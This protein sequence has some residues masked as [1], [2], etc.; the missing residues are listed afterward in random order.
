MRQPS[1]DS[2]SATSRR[3]CR[4]A[5]S[6]AARC[7]R[8]PAQLASVGSR[9]REGDHRVEAHESAAV[10]V[11]CA[12]GNGR[13]S[14]VPCGPTTT[15]LTSASPATRGGAHTPLRFVDPAQFRGE[16]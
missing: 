8:S 11:R 5:T 9:E 7:A 4:P 3:S 1:P 16:G 6:G 2:T 10:S 15:V 13:S 12:P 14:A